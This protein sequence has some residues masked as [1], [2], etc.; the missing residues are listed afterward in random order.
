[1]WTRFGAYF[2]ASNQTFAYSFP[3]AVVLAATLYYLSAS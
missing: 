3:A 2:A 1:M